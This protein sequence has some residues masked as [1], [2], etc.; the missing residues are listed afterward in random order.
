MMQEDPEDFFGD[1]D[2]FFAPYAVGARVIDGGD[3][4]RWLGVLG[5]G[6]I[7]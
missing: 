3:E 6:R 1:I 5:L 4:A 2:N 7:S